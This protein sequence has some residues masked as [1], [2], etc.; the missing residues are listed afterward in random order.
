MQIVSSRWDSASDLSGDANVFGPCVM[1]SVARGFCRDIWKGQWIVQDTMGSRRSII[2]FLF[3]S[4]FLARGK[5]G[6]AE[7]DYRCEILV[8]NKEERNGEDEP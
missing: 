2:L 1:C 8:L 4:T 6:D 3:V 7:R 5:Q